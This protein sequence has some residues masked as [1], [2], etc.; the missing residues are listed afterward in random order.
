MDYVHAFITVL[1]Y[2]EDEHN[3]NPLFIRRGSHSISFVHGYKQNFAV[4]IASV[5]NIRR[6]DASQV[7]I[8]L[9]PDEEKRLFKDSYKSS[10]DVPH[11][12]YMNFLGR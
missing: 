2:L 5:V 9:G 6:E 10:A 7:V 11:Y 8:P 4:D 3:F 1:K 12:S